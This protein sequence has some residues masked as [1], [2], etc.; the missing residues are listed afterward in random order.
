MKFLRNLLATIVGLFIF[1]IL[2]FFILAGIFSSLAQKE[3]V[4]TIRDNS[5]LH[6]NLNRPI[7]EKQPDV[8]FAS[9]P[10]PGIPKPLGLVELKQAIE[11]AKTDEKIKGIYLEASNVLTGYASLKEIRMALEDFKESGKFVVN[12]GEYYSEAGY[13]LASVADHMIMHPLGNMEFNGLKTTVLFF[14]GTLDKLEIE[15]VIF[16]VGEFKSAI[17]PFVRRDM[18]SENRQQLNA[19][20]NSIYDEM[21]INISRNRNKSVDE[22]EN[23][24]DSMLVFD[25]TSAMD[26]GMV[27]ELGFYDQL[28]ENLKD[29]IEVEDEDD[30]NMVKIDKYL[31]SYQ[32]NRDT[33]NRIAVI[34]ASGEIVMGEGEPGNIG[35]DRFVKAIRRA[36]KD[37]NVKAIVLRVNSPGGS[38]LASD[39]IW[40]ELVLA[41]KDKPVIASMSDLAASGG[42]YISM[43][44]DTIVANPTTITGSI[45]VFGLFFNI[46]DFLNEKLGITTDAVKTGEYADIFSLVRP[47]TE[48]ERSIIQNN[49]EDVYETFV[50][51]AAEGRNMSEEEIKAIAEGRVW[52]GI[53]AEEI[54][55]VDVI[56]NFEDALAIASEK[57]G[58]AEDDYKLRFYP[59]PKTFFEQLMEDFGAEAKTKLIK[60]E[61]GENYLY[62][63]HA[64][65][66]QNHV[67]IQTRMPFELVIE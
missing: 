31:H 50:S 46:Q 58:L 57:A 4:V 25:A 67:G 18:S 10:F 16:R 34:V 55:L 2:A 30:V 20:L 9:L 43:A 17:E 40:R 41:K 53:Q 47:L 38:A 26:Y 28:M 60:S 37:K 6:L 29:R 32:D 56:G 21:L 19:L 48:Y 42:Y 52:S 61:L 22:L 36:R 14:A 11:H 51:K 45:G 7:V 13:Y 65:Q 12:Y 15:P 23:I 44:C 33:R 54:G 64:K 8:P 35:S 59:A 5:V 27:N 3:K 39:A 24:S 62:Y 66:I 49:V 1:S 63:K